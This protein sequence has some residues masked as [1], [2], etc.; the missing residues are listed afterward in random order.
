ML[1]LL[2]QAQVKNIVFVHGAFADGSGYT[3]LYTILK[4]RG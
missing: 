3:K 1:S 2:V 4:A